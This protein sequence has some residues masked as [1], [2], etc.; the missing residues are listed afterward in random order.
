LCELAV[1]NGRNIRTRAERPDASSDEFPG[2]RVGDADA[3]P[4]PS[5]HDEPAAGGRPH[6]DPT[7]ASPATAMSLLALSTRRPRR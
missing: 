1:L 7:G 5:V 6:P 2:G 4:I 3:D